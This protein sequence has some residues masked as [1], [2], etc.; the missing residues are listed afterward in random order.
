MD[1]QD[2]ATP[3]VSPAVPDGPPP[4]AFKPLVK[5]PGLY[6]DLSFD[7]YARIAAINHSIL[8]LFKDTPLH[9][10]TQMLLPREQTPSMRLG[11][12]VHLAVLEPA[13]FAQTTA[14]APKVDRRTTV[15]KKVWNDFLREHAMHEIVKYEEM[16]VCRGVLDSVRQNSLVM[17]LLSGKGANELTLV[18]EDKEYGVPCKSRLD[19]VRALGNEPVIVDCKTSADPV[20]LRNFQKAIGNFGYHEQAAMYREGLQALRPRETPYRFL[21][22]A[23]ETKPPYAVRV[24]E[25]EYDALEAGYQQHREHLRQYAECLKHDIWPGYPPGIETAGLPAWM[26]KTFDAE[27]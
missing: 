2:E 4:E 6:P 23:I 21:W 15:G 18:W 19:G 26:Q 17:E 24:F 25:C 12:L 8:R 5:A 9:A 27:L 1:D 16:E 20:S 11:Y 10:R 14:V 3:E 7:E 22:I 13:R